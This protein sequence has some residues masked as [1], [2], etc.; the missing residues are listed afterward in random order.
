MTRCSICQEGIG[1]DP[2]AS[3]VGGFFP[4]EEPDLFMVDEEILSESHVHMTCLKD[5]L[6]ASLLTKVHKS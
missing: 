3:L 6:R 4:R 2:A 1:A 5:A